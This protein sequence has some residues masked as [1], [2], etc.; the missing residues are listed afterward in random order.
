MLRAKQQKTGFTKELAYVLR[1]AVYSTIGEDDMIQLMSQD[2]G[3]TESQV[4]MACQ[5]LKKQF[6][7]MLL[8]GHSLQ[9]GDIGYVRFSISAKSVKNKENVSASLV[10]GCR[11]LL[12]ASGELREALQNV[13]FNVTE[14]VD[15]DEQ[16]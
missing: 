9:L 14:E 12:R 8:R 2:S 3:I 16:P 15:A 10:R 1:N 6:Q 13:G 11:V 7:Q 5:A 4:Y